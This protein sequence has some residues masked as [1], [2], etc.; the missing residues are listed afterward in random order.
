MIDLSLHDPYW[1]TGDGVDEAIDQCAHGRILFK[2]NT[3]EF[4]RPVDGTWTVS[5]AGLHLLRTLEYSNSSEQPVSEDSQL[6][7]CCG[8]NVW[9]LESSRF[10]F[11]MIGCLDGIEL[12]ILHK[13]RIVEVRSEDGRCEVVC[14]DEWSLAVDQFVAQVEQFYELSKP[15]HIPDDELNAQGWP[16]FWAEWNARRSGLHA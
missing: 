14:R 8:F 16:L 15:K 11:S 6:I 13:D 2:L 9:P 5:A 4:V 7:P 1:M 3:T 12:E 10:G